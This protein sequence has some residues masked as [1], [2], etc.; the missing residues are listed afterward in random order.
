MYPFQRYELID[1]LRNNN[2]STPEVKISDVYVSNKR[3]KQ[4]QRRILKG[5]NINTVDTA[6]REAFAKDGGAKPKDFFKVVAKAISSK[7][8]SKF[9]AYPSLKLHLFIYTHPQRVFF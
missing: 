7:D 1:I 9:T 5:F 4:T 3:A 6:L 2:F 8:K